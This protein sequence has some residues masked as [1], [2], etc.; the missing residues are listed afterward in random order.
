M[1]GRTRCSGARGGTGTGTGR[2]AGVPRSGMGTGTRVLGALRLGV[3]LLLLGSLPLPPVCAPSESKCLQKRGPGAGWGV[4][5]WGG[6]A[7]W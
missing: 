2:D 1:R 3:T 5:A 4:L 6:G 7:A